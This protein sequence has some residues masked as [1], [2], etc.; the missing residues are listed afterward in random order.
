MRGGLDQDFSFPKRFPDKTDVA[1]LEVS[2]SAVDKLGG[3]AAGPGREIRFF[4]QRDAQS[5]ESRIPGHS[6][7]HDPPA[8]Y[9]DVEFPIL[10]RVEVH[11]Q[12]P[13]QTGVSYRQKRR[14]VNLIRYSRL[15]S[16][17]NFISIRSKL[18]VLTS[19][20]RIGDVRE[21]PC[22]G[23]LLPTEVV[24]RRL[25]LVTLI[26]P[27]L[28]FGLAQAPVRAQLVDA[29][30]VVGQVTAKKGDSLTV[31]DQATELTVL[32]TERTHVMLKSESSSPQAISVGD[33]IR[34]VFKEESGKKHALV[35]DIM[36]K[37]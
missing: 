4:D 19:V 30:S 22:S 33:E 21:V 11:V 31:Q 28:L 13:A 9:D 18:D 1:H 29:K 27:V 35:V 20:S 34:L 7:A 25:A 24:M 26:L 6:G 12:S 2:K 36:N 32:L 23:L 17:L 10:N 15:L 16:D 3:S 5:A 37:K 8:N 14:R